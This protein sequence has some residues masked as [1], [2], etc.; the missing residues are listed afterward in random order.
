VEFDEID[1]Q[2]VSAAASGFERVRRAAKLQLSVSLLTVS[3]LSA[4]LTRVCR[5]AYDTEAFSSLFYEV[6]SAGNTSPNAS[7]TSRR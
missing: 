4:S 7:S 2:R 1:N 6:S 3:L 5:R